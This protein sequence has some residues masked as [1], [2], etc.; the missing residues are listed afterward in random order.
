MHLALMGATGALTKAQG[1]EGPAGW[2]GVG[3]AALG[4]GVRWLLGHWVRE[5]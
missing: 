2:L 3:V 4:P 1:A 5:G